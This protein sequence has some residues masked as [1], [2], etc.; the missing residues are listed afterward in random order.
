[1]ATADET[2]L[3][4]LGIGSILQSEIEKLS[5]EQLRQELFDMHMRIGERLCAHDQFLQEA[6][7]SIEGRNSAG[8]RARA[9]AMEA[10]FGP[11]KA[12]AR[13]VYDAMKA[14]GGRSPPWR[15]FYDEVEKRFRA[16]PWKNDTLN[17]WWKA[18]NAGKP[19]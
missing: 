19:F 12:K 10:H 13:G 2:D 16:D 4:Y 5:M 11:L 8:G 17:D 18:M 3:R 6:L 15:P 14:K 9:L 1:M 7:V